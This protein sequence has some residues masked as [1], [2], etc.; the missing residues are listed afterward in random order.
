MSC[1]PRLRPVGVV[2]PCALACACV[3]SGCGSSDSR[4]AAG[5]AGS[6]SQPDAAVDQA[7]PDAAQEAATG[8]DAWPE[9][10]PDSFQCLAPLQA[11][12]D[13]S[14]CC[15]AMACDLVGAMAGKSCCFGL[16]APCGAE[17]GGCCGDLRCVGN[18]G[19]ETCLACGLS[20]HGCA[21]P[22]DCCPGFQCN[23]QGTCEAI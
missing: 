14:E 3:V 9:A 23:A 5:D 8:D 12:S 15:E 17:P 7:A 19:F 16:H 18:P 10:A 4:G 13:A 6:A 11:C 22:A 2:L 21:V 1:S 20:G